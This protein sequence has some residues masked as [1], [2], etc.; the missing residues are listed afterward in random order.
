MVY[1]NK[2]NCKYNKYKITKSYHHDD[3]AKLI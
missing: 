3:N 1:Q 2:S